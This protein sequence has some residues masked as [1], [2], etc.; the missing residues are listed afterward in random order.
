MN[1]GGV[2][3]C[4]VTDKLYRESLEQSRAPDKGRSASLLRTARMVAI[5]R[6]LGYDGVH[7][8]GPNLRY[9][10]VE[11]VIGTSME[12][13]A[14]WKALVP[15]FEYPIPF[16]FYLYEREPATGLNTNAYS[17]RTRRPTK[18]PG[19]GLMRLFHRVAFAEG[20]PFYGAACSIFKSLD[21]S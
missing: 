7:I 8:G 4:V 9:E 2:P 12:L 17:P 6:E 15:L 20:A 16:G 21:G 13:S 14:D 18:A 10:D 11:W 3:G 19:Y 5:L 1:A